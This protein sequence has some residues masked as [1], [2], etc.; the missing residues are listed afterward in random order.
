MKTIIRE[1]PA[2]PVNGRLIAVSD[3]HGYVHYLKGLL[4]KI[5][6]SSQ[7]TLIIIGDMIEKGPESLATVRFIRRMIRDGFHVSVSMG[8]VEQSRL[9]DLIA[10]TSAADQRFLHTLQKDLT[11]WKHGLF[12][13]MMDELGIS[14]VSVSADNAAALKQSLLDNYRPE[15]EWLLNL[16]TVLTA[17]SFIFAHAGIPTDDLARLG[18]ADAME[19][20][21]C[22][23]FLLKDIR[24]TR[25]IVTGHWPV[26]LYRED[27]DSMRPIFD[28]EKHIIALDG[29]CAL[30]AGAQLN[31]LILP[32]S[33]ADMSE[34]QFASYDDFPVITAD[35]P[36]QAR[37]ATIHI[38]YFNCSVDIL[39]ELDDLVRLRLISTGQT[40]L[41]P[42]SLLFFHPGMPPQCDDYSDALLEVNTGDSLSVIKD[43]SI[44]KIVKK[45]GIIGWYL[46]PSA[47]DI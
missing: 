37:T 6:F 21:K 16:P 32:G 46:D 44:G 12:L 13:D 14:P 24:F 7:D 33:A 27:I 40:F 47:A 9:A 20:L 18:S 42:K 4:A 1:I 31:A 30:K 15:I 5:H 39:E 19:C 11:V 45:D 43:T 38:R 22:D 2:P 8:N 3:I 25:Y 35:H 29:G 26:T 23:A 10:Q 28:A 17:G 34:A 41:A 36:Q